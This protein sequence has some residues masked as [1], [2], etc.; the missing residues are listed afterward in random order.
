MPI[1]VHAAALAATSTQMDRLINGQMKEAN[2]KRAEIPDISVE[3]FTR[4][5]EY[6]YRGDYAAPSYI[7]DAD[8]MAAKAERAS[9]TEDPEQMPVSTLR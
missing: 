7:V 5:C 8:R 2:D 6:A 9:T 3:D 1:V 4:F